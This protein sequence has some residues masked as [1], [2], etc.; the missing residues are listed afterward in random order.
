MPAAARLNDPD[1]SDGAVTSA[2]AGTV[3]IN[4]LPAAIVGSMNRDHAP[5]G[6]PH[7]PHVPNAIVSGS[8]SVTIEG[9]PAARV[10]DPFEC[11][12]TISAG[13]GDVDI[14]G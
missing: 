6:I 14:G 4:G 5:Y 7:P 9:Q 11:G 10:G 13:S 2:T 8:G 3:T 1:D 12:H